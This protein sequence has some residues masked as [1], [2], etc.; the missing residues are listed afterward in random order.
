M[1]VKTSKPLREVDNRDKD[2]VIAYYEARI[3]VLT[4]EVEALRRA[5][6]IFNDLGFSPEDREWLLKQR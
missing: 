6:T 5:S 3:E 1:T 2:E 4:A